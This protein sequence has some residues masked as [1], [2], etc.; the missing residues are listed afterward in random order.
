MNITT[1]KIYSEVYQVLEVLGDEYIGKL[2]IR[3]FN[4]IK[5]KRDI[6]YNP[7][8]TTEIPLNIQNMKKE[9]LKIIALLHL[10]Y[11]CENDEERIE[12]EKIL[13]NNE[14]KYTTE[15]KGKYSLKKL[16]NKDFMEQINENQFLEVKQEKT[17]LKKI[18]EKIRKILNI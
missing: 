7:I 3:L 18:I 1:K 13:K 16:N 9:T 14:E 10:N 6:Y 15:N 5:E 8:Y 11:W 2:P 17:T 4:M 12:L